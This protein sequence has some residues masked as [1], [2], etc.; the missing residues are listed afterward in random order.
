MSI[1]ASELRNNLDKYL[2][3]ASTEEILITQNGQVIAKLSSP[4]QEKN[5]IVQ[6]LYGCIPAELNAEEAREERLNRI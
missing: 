6:A 5:A 3:M 1:T 2:R 4:F